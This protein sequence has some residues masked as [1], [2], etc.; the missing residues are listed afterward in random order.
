M[1]QACVLQG[2]LEAGAGQLD[3]ED[4]LL[5]TLVAHEAL[6]AVVVEAEDAQA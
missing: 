1:A 3:R 2:P 4:P 5:P 6:S